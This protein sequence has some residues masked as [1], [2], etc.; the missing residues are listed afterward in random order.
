M[1]PDFRK[2]IDSPTHSLAQQLSTIMPEMNGHRHATLLQ[3]IQL[4][5]SVPEYINT[6]ADRTE[7]A[8]SVEARMPLFDHKVV[9]L[10]MGLP[11]EMKLKGDQ[12]KWIL[13][14][15]FRSDLP[16]SVLGRRKQAFLAPP[17]PFST[18]EGRML[19]ETYLSTKA[20]NESGIWST[21]RIGAIKAARR[22]MPR[23]RMINLT[24]TI[25]LTTQILFHRFIKHQ[26]SWR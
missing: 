26:P 23:N 3:Y 11:I 4:N 10:A 2:Q 16:A 22:V 18:P 14:E 5:S 19:L 8:G 12:E 15:A 25:V 21:Q 24:L 13:R 6:I 20:L 1:S 9:E 17:A 7:N